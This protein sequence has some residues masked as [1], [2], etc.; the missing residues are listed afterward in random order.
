MSPAKVIT[1]AA[2]LLLAVPAAPAGAHEIKFGT[3]SIRHPWSRQSAV[4]GVFG[5]YTVITNNGPAD[6]R[7]VAATAEIAGKA[8]IHDAASNKD[9]DQG[10]L[11]PAG[12]AVKLSPTTF[13]I[14]F[15]GVT[16]DLEEGEVFA[17]TMTF[18]HAGTVKVDFEVVASAP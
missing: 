10:L 6:D 2:A 15:E 11:I 3:L 14:L 8:A 12:S 1:L 9:L 5:G 7:L 18:A 16:Q 13:E 4:P 17:G